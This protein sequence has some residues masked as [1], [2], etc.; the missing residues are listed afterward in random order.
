MTLFENI[1]LLKSAWNSLLTIAGAMGLLSVRVVVIE[2]IQAR[3]YINYPKVARKAD[4]NVMRVV[5]NS[6]FAKIRL[7]KSRACRL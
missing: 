1:A 6:R 2:P 7:W 5:K 4:S 3:K